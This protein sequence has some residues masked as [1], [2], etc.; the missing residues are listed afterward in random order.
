[1]RMVGSS[2]GSKM[3]PLPTMQ[4][5]GFFTMAPLPEDQA[6]GF[7]VEVKG[8]YHN[9]HATP[10]NWSWPELPKQKTDYVIDGFSPNLNKFLHIGHL[11]NLALAKSLSEILDGSKFVAML[12]YSLGTIEGAEHKLNE[13]LNFVDYHPDYYRDTAMGEVELPTVPGEGEFEGCEV[14]Q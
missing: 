4:G 14:W 13:W 7:R 5:V 3:R 10:A 2:T 6:K 11:R 8:R 9:Y 1:M 12:G